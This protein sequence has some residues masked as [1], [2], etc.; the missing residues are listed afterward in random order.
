[1][2]MRALGRS[3][4]QAKSFAFGGNVFGWTADEKTSHAMLDMCVN[5]PSYWHPFRCSGDSTPGRA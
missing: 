2:E 3:G 5:R 1:M 4:L